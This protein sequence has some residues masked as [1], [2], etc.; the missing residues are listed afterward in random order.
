MKKGYIIAETAKHDYINGTCHR[1][2]WCKESTRR[3]TISTIIS[4]GDQLEQEM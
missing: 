3:S 4:G 1:D 2:E